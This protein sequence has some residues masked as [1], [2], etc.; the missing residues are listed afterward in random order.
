MSHLRTA[1]NHTKGHYL[2]IEAYDRGNKT[3]IEDDLWLELQDDIQIYISVGKCRST[4]NS[5]AD[6]LYF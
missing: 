4:F 6:I 5:V 1:P 3:R 2:C